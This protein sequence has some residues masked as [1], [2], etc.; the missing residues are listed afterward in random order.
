MAHRK[1][2][3]LNARQIQRL[4]NLSSSKE[5]IYISRACKRAGT[6][7]IMSYHSVE[8]LRELVEMINHRP[9]HRIEICH[10]FPVKDER[11]IGLLHPLNLVYGDSIFNKKAGNKHNGD[12]GESICKTLLLDKWAITE[13]M[14]DKETLRIVQKFLGRVLKEYVKLYP[15]NKWARM[16]VVD[17]IM[18]RDPTDTYTREMLTTKDSFELSI[19]NAKLNG[20]TLTGTYY[21]P[22]KAQSRIFVYL[23]ELI[24]I[25][26]DIYGAR[27]KNCEFMLDIMLASA[28][29][30][31]KAPY[32]PEIL[33]TLNPYL[34]KFG[35]YKEFRLRVADEATYSKFKHFLFYQASDCLLGN[36]INRAMINAT[37]NKYVEG[38]SISVYSGINSISLEGCHE[39]CPDFT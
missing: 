5:W 13:H 30:L 35:P 37:F 1:K 26:C 12:V 10:V 9:S 25:S 17:S 4:K 7:Q 34:Q 2:D 27:A 22:V 20:V 14:T 11:R 16:K 3:G 32:Q 18:L 29:A 15:V 33:C 19:I 23:N 28:I 21:P 39:Y 31:S 8:S 36:N 24:R 38:R 6:V